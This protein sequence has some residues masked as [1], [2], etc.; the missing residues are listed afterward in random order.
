MKQ[1]VYTVKSPLGIHV[2]A[3]GMIVKLAKEYADT[4][5][6]ISCNG[7]EEKATSL[8]KLM[9]LGVKQGNKITVTA[10]G[11]NEDTAILAM[12]RFV[13]NNL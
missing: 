7:K 8:M 6:S 11:A 4:A 13:N 5:I 2:R 3:S 9:A 1:Y 10:K 12:S